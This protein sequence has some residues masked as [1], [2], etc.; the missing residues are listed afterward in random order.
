MP[1]VVRRG[2]AKRGLVRPRATHRVWVEHCLIKIRILRAGRVQQ[3][4][5]RIP[6]RHRLDENHLPRVSTLFSEIEIGQHPLS[7]LEPIGS[8]IVTI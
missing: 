6:P 1:V 2:E 5:H 4:L 8:R 7:V 3:G